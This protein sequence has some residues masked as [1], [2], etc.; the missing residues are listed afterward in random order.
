MTSSTDFEVLKSKLYLGASGIG[1]GFVEDKIRVDF[2][3]VRCLNNYL[4][5][6]LI[7]NWCL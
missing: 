3:L 6:L 7:F 1:L 4:S 2:I 5:S